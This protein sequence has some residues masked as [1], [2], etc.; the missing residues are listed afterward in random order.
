M[1]ARPRGAKSS[2]TW[3]EIENAALISNLHGFRRRLGTGVELS[4]V[5]KS[6][7]YG[8]GLELVAREDEASGLVHSLSVISVE[9]LIRV[10]EAGVK[11]PVII[12]GY[13]PMSAWDVVVDAEGSP[14]IM[15]RES[16][17]VLSGE[18]AERGRSVKVHLKVETG[19]HRYGVPEEEVLEYVQL[20][21]SLPGL[22]L[23][24]VT[25]HFAN[26]EDTTDHGFAQEQIDRFRRTISR[27]REAG[28]DV[29]LPHA[30]CSA[31]TILFPESHFAMARV[32][33]ASYGIWPSKETRVS[34][35]HVEGGLLDLKPILTWKTRV[36]QVK[37]VPKGAYVGYGCTWRAPT[38][39]RL[40]VLPVGYA[41]GYDRG[42]SNVGHVLIRGQ[43]AP[44]RGRI[45]MNV[46]MVDITH[47][48]DV[49]LEDE[50]VLLGAQGDE[51]I[52]AEDLAGW[53][54]T[55]AYEIAARIAEHIPRVRVQL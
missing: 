51:R 7:A 33:I 27:I 28:Y 15:N 46:C 34:A 53:C 5:V 38:D 32:G 8:H 36:A 1:T 54:G 26:I 18:A 29:P 14:V 41:D 44:I 25:T 35:S 11:L 50:V 17:E 6:N 24:G 42:L 10:R 12:L 4:H 21:D 45:C 22:Y 20:I 52:H 30:A 23:A 47:I 40:A 31:A 19:T 2:L 16:L 37:R 43:R 9:E 13:V 49:E 3:V 55:I 48:P 39:T